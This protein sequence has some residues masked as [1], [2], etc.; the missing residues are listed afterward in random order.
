[1]LQ[2]VLIQRWHGMCS[3]V[4]DQK[5]EVLRM[6][7]T[8]DL[9]EQ[10]FLIETV[11]SLLKAAMRRRGN[12]ID[13]PVYFYM[14]ASCTIEGVGAEC[15]VIETSFIEKMRVT[16]MLTELA[17]SITPLTCLVLN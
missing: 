9:K 5:D 7:C 12:I 16:V 15:A 13:V 2:F 17:D 10:I 1:M 4:T 3:I 6:V 11:F 8:S 14:P